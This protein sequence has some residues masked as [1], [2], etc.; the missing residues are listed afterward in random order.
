MDN[1][2]VHVD[3]ALTASAVFGEQ[4]DAPVAVIL[5]VSFDSNDP[6]LAASGPLCTITTG[7][8]GELTFDLLM[9]DQNAGRMENYSMRTQRTFAVTTSSGGGVGAPPYADTP[10]GVSETGVHPIVVPHALW[11]A[12]LE[13]A[14]TIG[15]TGDLDAD[16]DVDLVDYA[17]FMRMIGESGGV[18]YV[19]DAENRLT[20]VIPVSPQGGE[21]QKVEYVYD[22]LGRRVVRRVYGW[23]AQ[24]GDWTGPAAVTKYVYDGWRVIMELD[25]LDEDAV[26]RRYTWG[27][28]LSGSL[29]GA[30]GIGGLLAAEDTAG[31]AT[32]ADDRTFIYFA[33]GNGNI[34]QVVETTAGQNYGTVAVQYEYDP[35]GSR[36]NTPAQNEYDQPFRFS[37]KPF[38][39]VTGLGYWGFRHYSPSLGRWMNRDPLGEDGGPRLYGYAGNM[40]S[41]RIDGF[42]LWDER[43][44]KKLTSQL[45]FWAGIPCFDDLGYWA[46]YPDIDPKTAPISNSLGSYPGTVAGWMFVVLPWDAAQDLLYEAQQARESAREWHFPADKDG[47]VRPGSKVS[48]YKAGLA[49]RKCDLKEF[50]RGLHVLQDSWSHQGR[51]YKAGFGHA[52]GAIKIPMPMGLPTQYIKLSGLA[53]ATSTSADDPSI[54]QGDVLDA[55]S[56]TYRAMLDFRTNCPCGCPDGRR[57]TRQ[58]KDPKDIRGLATEWFKQMLEL[59]NFDGS[60]KVPWDLETE[61]APQ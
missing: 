54:W 11:L 44:H 39:D 61:S 42:G 21:D 3:D 18:R 10:N 19:W 17:L 51:P 34:G 20:A 23:D 46:N 1:Y 14:G 9:V 50:G 55:A 13:A 8:T 36:V 58:A 24:A 5:G 53:A 26:T 4:A 41:Q 56:T 57:M 7:A 29:E 16:G 38:D 43:I 32:T 6:A 60:N 31:T 52:R 37:T 15:T 33:D 22:Y 35:F 12:A 59:R 30:G 48:R 2:E 40:P 27:L 49:V 28:D 45:A 47:V 25:G